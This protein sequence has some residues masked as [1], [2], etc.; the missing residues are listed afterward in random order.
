MWFR[1]DLRNIALAH[2]L[3][4][5][6]ATA[7]RKRKSMLAWFHE[8][9]SPE[10]EEIHERGLRNLHSCRL[11]PGSNIHCTY[12]I[13]GSEQ[14]TNTP[15]FDTLRDIEMYSGKK[16]HHSINVLIVVGLN[17]RILWLSKSMGGNNN[18]ESLVK[19]DHGWL[20][21]FDRDNQLQTI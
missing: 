9:L 6:K 8:Q 5:S 18:D 19:K 17:G 13:D 4:I 3:N 1:H 7:D 16:G 15:W 12:V 20:S 21:L 10:L 2:L 11:F 14:F